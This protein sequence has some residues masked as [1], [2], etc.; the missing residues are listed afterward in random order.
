MGQLQEEPRMFPGK[1]SERT[2]DRLLELGYISEEPDSSPGRRIFKLT[3]AG[4]ERGR[5]EG[6]YRDA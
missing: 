1:V 4:R 3:D 2:M 6:W 5:R